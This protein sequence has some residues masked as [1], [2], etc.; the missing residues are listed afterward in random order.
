MKQYRD[1]WRDWKDPELDKERWS[2]LC[3]KCNT[4]YTESTSCKYPP[5]TWYKKEIDNALKEIQRRFG[6]E[7]VKPSKKSS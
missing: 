5:K 4:Q 3:P 1:D 2:D 7:R 6:T